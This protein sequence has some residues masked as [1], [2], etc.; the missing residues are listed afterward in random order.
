MECEA[1]ECGDSVLGTE[2][3]EAAQPAE[4]IQDSWG[5]DIDLSGA[6]DEDLRDGAQTEATESG[7]AGADGAQEQHGDGG[8]ENAGQPVPEQAASAMTAAQAARGRLRE[9]GEM[10]RELSMQRMAKTSPRLAERYLPGSMAGNMRSG[11][12]MREAAATWRSEQLLA[13][14]LALKQEKAN[15][16]RVVGSAGSAG[17]RTRDAFDEQWYDGT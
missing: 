14:N 7:R 1:Y 12:S 9:I 2:S 4:E 11:M 8:G 10:R 17:R 16:Q 5:G 13:E 3:A 6:P 15:A